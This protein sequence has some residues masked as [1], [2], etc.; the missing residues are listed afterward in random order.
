M[1]NHIRRC[2]NAASDMALHC[3]LTEYTFSNGLIN[4]KNAIASPE[5]G[6]V[7]CS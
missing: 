4:S 3:F 2:G 1:Q 6:L 7:V 5:K